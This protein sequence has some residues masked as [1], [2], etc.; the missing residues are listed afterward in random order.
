MASLMKSAG[1]RSVNCFIAAGQMGIAPLRE[2]MQPASNQTSMTSDTRRHA[3]RGVLGALVGNGVDVGLVNFEV[4]DQLGFCA[5][6]FSHHVNALDT[7]LG[8]E[9]GV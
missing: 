3:C 4:V 2:G 8:H 1:N 9:F 5:L 6:A 7:G